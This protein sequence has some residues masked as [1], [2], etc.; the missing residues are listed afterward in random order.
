VIAQKAG[1][2]YSTAFQYDAIQRKGTDEQ[3]AKVGETS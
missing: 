1:V 2:G 3:K